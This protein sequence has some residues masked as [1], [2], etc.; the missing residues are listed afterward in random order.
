M[1][2]LVLSGHR[3]WLPWAPIT[4]AVLLL[5]LLAYRV[6]LSLARDWPH[7]LEETP[8]VEVSRADATLW[9]QFGLPEHGLSRVAIAM[10]L[11]FVPIACLTYNTPMYMFVVLVV[12]MQCLALL[13]TC[14]VAWWVAYCIVVHR[15]ERATGVRLRLPALP[16]WG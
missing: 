7:P 8:G 6:R 1:S 16:L 15:W 10:L 4:S 9:R 13:T 2:Y 5:G 11:V 12:A 3:D 14:V